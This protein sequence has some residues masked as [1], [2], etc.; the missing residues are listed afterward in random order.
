MP[1]EIAGTNTSPERWRPCRRSSLRLQLQGQQAII[2]ARCREFS[3]TIQASASNN[4]SDFVEIMMHVLASPLLR[5]LTVAACISKRVHF[6]CHLTE[7]PAASQNACRLLERTFSGR[8]VAGCASPDALR[9]FNNSVNLEDQTEIS[10]IREAPASHA[11]RIPQKGRSTAAFSR[12]ALESPQKDVLAAI[13]S[14]FWKRTNHQESGA[15][16]AQRIA[17]NTAGP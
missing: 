8:R 3:S 11:R 7:F 13:G 6:R 12:S 15:G 16:F 4:D 1:N 2:R 10:F 5:W 14:I 9:R 17:A